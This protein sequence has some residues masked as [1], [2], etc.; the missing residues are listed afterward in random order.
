M[1]H[2][3]QVAGRIQVLQTFDEP[4]FL[5]EEPMQRVARGRGRE[6]SGARFGKGLEGSRWVM[7]VGGGE[8]PWLGVTTTDLVAASKSQGVGAP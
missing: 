3:R 8:L 4:S 7:A 5:H 2:F 6:T 1:G